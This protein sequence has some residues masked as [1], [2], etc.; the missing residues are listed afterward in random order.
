MSEP[1]LFLNVISRRDIISIQSSFK[2]DLTIPSHICNM[3]AATLLSAYTEFNH[4][5][6]NQ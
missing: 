2:R 1:T 6:S 3:N 4:H 5:P